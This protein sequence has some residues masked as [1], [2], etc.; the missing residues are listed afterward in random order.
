MIA[1]KPKIELRKV[2]ESR[3]L[4]EETPAY[5]AQ[6][7]VDGAHFCDVSNHGQGG[8]D[9]YRAPKWHGG[10]AML[11]GPLIV[12]NQRIATTFPPCTYEAGGETHSF[13][14]DLELVC[15]ELLEQRSIDKRVDRLLKTKVMWIRDGK[16]YEFRIKGEAQ[17][18]ERLVAYVRKREPNA[19]FLHD[20]TRDEVVA[21]LVA[22]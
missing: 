5:S 4:S 14:R 19:R 12:L 20:M 1:T 2:S 15:H 18:R 10:A 3:S 13:P 22:P 21:L 6:V 11:D 8:P 16:V 9:M 17:S 7:W